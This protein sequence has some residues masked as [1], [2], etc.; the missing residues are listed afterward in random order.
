MKKRILFVLQSLRTGGAERVQVTIANMLAEAGYDVTILIWKPLYT[1]RDDL[2]KRVRLIYKAPDEHLG[3]RIPYIR[4]KFYDDCMWELRA[5]PRQLY[6]YYVGDEKFDVE[7]AF[8]YGLAP[9]IVG[10]STNKKAKKIAW[11]H[12]NLEKLDMEEALAKEMYHKIRHIVCVSRASRDSFLR[13]I[14]DTGD[15]SVIYN[16]LPISEIREKAQETPPVPVRKAG[17]HIVMVARYHAPKGYQRLIETIVQLNREGKEL[18]LALIG[19]GDEKPIILD[20]IR[21]HGA[22]DY[23]SAV[24][25]KNNPYP[26]IKE[27]DLLVCSSFKEGFNLT[28]GEAMILGVP[29]LSTDCA[30]PREILDGGKYGMLVENS[31]EGIYQG[32]K[33]LYDSPALLEEYRKKAVERQGFFDNQKI[34]SQIIEMIEG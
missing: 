12:N 7:I 28:I 25:G 8:F 19:E 6:R 9:K 1:F 11:I 16:P 24:D 22:Q 13:V 20:L 23:I 15:V 10:G 31:K 21:K 18:S 5:S 14:G 26:Y 27:A 4:Y 32:V 29:V 2:D 34:F 17:F 3:N 30:G 33:A